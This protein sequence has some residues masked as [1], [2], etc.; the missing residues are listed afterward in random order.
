MAERVLSVE[1]PF[2]IGVEV[3]RVL[4]AT[5]NAELPVLSV[6][7]SHKGYCSLAALA[8]ILRVYA[9]TLVEVGFDG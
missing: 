7:G 4:P 9:G 3:S 8:V 6:L 2:A 5:M 1:S